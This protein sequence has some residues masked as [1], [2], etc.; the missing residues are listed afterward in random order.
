M[1]RVMI[2]LQSTRYGQSVERDIEAAH[3]F[4]RCCPPSVSSVGFF[5]GLPDCAATTALFE[6]LTRRPRLAVLELP[7]FIGGASLQ[8]SLDMQ[9]TDAIFADL[10]QLDIRL[11]SRHVHMI[12]RI[13]P[14][15][16]QLRLNIADSEVRALPAL[17]PLTQLTDLA[18]HYV[19]KAT[20]PLDSEATALGRLHNLRA[21]SIGASS[22]P[23]LLTDKGLAGTLQS[24][25]RLKRL[26]LAFWNGI[27]NLSG[28]AICAVGEQCRDLERLELSG[29]WDL[30]SWRRSKFKSLFPR[31]SR[32]WLEGA[33]L[34]AEPSPAVR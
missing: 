17:A 32:L 33:S 30:S 1:Q 27:L 7:G 13:A 29:E 21:L 8:A 10:G 12:P 18:V 11:A 5:D 3:H 28:A 2:A 23:L 34:A 22:Q 26:R 6:H 16:K 4:L 24:L 14:A 19:G 20:P 25:P 15:L 9:T 31:L